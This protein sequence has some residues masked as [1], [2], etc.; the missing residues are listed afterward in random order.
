M[1]NE[2]RFDAARPLA[3]SVSLICV[4]ANGED[5]ATYRQWAS[6]GILP[7]VRVLLLPDGQALRA[8]VEKALPPGPYGMVAAGAAAPWAFALAERQTGAY[9]LIRLFLAAAPADVAGAAGA[10]LVPVVGLAAAESPAIPPTAVAGWQRH[11]TSP[12]GVRL[13]GSGAGFLRTSTNQV[14]TVIAEELL[15]P[16]MK[17]PDDL[18]DKAEERVSVALP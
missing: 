9:P 15:V 3:E 10:C 8:G 17:I 6:S 4:A 2:Q 11:C 12:V 13:C 5:E 18:Q 1:T 16:P 14:L 7:D